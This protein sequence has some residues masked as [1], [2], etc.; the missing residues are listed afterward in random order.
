MRPSKVASPHQASPTIPT[1]VRNTFAKPYRDR[2]E[3]L[4]FRGSMSRKA[5][6]YDNALAESFMKTLKR[7]EASV[8]LQHYR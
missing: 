5:N 1:L 2:V 4:G 6:P 7:E 8:Q 3:Q